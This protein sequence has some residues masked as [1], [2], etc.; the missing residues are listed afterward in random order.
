MPVFKP[1][2]L[3]A[4][5]GTRVA[6]VDQTGMV[7]LSV[8]LRPKLAVAPGLP[9]GK[10]LT[11]AE[12]RHRHGKAETVMARVRDLARSYGIAARFEDAGAHFMELR[13]TYAQAIAAFQPDDIGVYDFAPGRRGVGR[14]GHLVVPEDIAGDVVAAMGLHQRPVAR[15]HFRRPASATAS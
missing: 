6:D 4:P 12:Y 15:P 2:Q 7:G 8:V 3:P 1:S 11:H 13:G 9:G 10:G 14:T 5:P